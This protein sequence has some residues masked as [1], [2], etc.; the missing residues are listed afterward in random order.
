MNALPQTPIAATTA[1]ASLE[2]LPMQAA[3]LDEVARIECEVHAFPWGRGNFADAINAGYSCWV[4][5]CAGQ[6][7]GYFVLMLAVDDA[8]L[9][10]ISVAGKHHGRGFGGQLLRAALS[11]ARQGRATVFLLE[12]RPSNEKALAIYRHFGFAQVGVRRGYYPAAGGREDAL[13]LTRAL[14]EVS[15]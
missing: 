2:L 9:L 10:T 8:H 13:V 4:G 11:A 6:L 12:V 14:V 15:A 1:R 5:R 7:V 3:D